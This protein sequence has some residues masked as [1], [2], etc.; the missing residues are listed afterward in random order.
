MKYTLVICIRY[1]DKNWNLETYR[2]DK[3]RYCVE[4]MERFKRYNPY[5]NEVSAQVEFPNGTPELEKLLREEVDSRNYTYD[6]GVGVT[7]SQKDIKRARFVP[8][9]CS[10]VHGADYD[11]YGNN[12]NTYKEVLCKY[13][14]RTN[15]RNIP[16]PYLI[17]DKRVKKPRDIFSAS[18]GIYILSVLAFTLLQDEIEPWVDYGP[19]QIVDKNK[20][21]VK[22]DYKYIWIRPKIEVGPFVN[23]RIKQVC[24]KCGQPTEIRIDYSG[25]IFEVGKETVESFNNTEAPIVIAGNWFGEINTKETSNHSRYVFIS[26]ELH[27]RMRK[28]KL[29]GFLKADRVI[30]AADEPYEWD[31]L[32]YRHSS[33]FSRD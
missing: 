19:V 27:E 32:R 7:Y 8:L 16:T 4:L 31:P 5:Y 13:C 28:L 10:G 29:K 21:P 6:I 20:K 23:S 33:A 2:E 1:D 25:D 30:H 24:N 15:D 18:N 26:S 12:L 22:S 9:C 11:D 14:G 3:N 17:Y